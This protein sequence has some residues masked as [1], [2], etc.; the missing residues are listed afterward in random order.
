MSAIYT[1]TEQAILCDYFKIPRLE[2][3]E[4]IDIN[5]KTESNGI[6]LPQ[7]ADIDD[8][9][10]LKNAVARIALSVIQDR[11]PQCGVFDGEGNLTLTRD[12]FARPSRDVIPLPQHLFMIN[13]A[14][15]APGVSWPEAYHVTY[16][17]WFD[18]YVVTAS[19][20]GTDMHGVTELAIGH[21]DGALTLAE[22]SGD[23]VKAWWR[24][25]MSACCQDRWAYVWDNGVI[26]AATANA[27]A[28][29]VWADEPDDEEGE[30]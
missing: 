29:E 24:Y 23:V 28:D 27:W 12:Q 17:P 5:E 26:D 1:P 16:I 14:D 22:A 25:L 4:S 6:Y 13:W 18:R 19:L 20:D 10:A 8:D 3:C 11:L 30:D 15:T 7:G 21:F 9:T 2:G